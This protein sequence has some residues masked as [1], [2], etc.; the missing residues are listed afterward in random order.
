MLDLLL[1]CFVIDFISAR[2]I[3]L[4]FELHSTWP[5]Q[6]DQYSRDYYYYLWPPGSAHLYRTFDHVFACLLERL[7]EY[8]QAYGKSTI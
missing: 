5:G 3:Q 4:V 7:P 6:E 8:G 2:L 1:I